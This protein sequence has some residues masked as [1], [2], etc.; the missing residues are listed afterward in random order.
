MQ[1]PRPL[2]FA[3]L[4][5][6][7]WARYQ[8][9]AWQ[10]VAG[11]QCVAIYNRTLE[12]AQRLA[13]EFNI[14]QATDDA[15]NLLS[16]QSLD[17]VDIVTD[18]D[19]HS[20]FVHLAAQHR[21]PAIC[22]KPLAPSLAVAEK[23][24]VACRTAGVPLLVHENFR[25]QRPMREVK[26]IL[27]E[28]TIGRPFRARIDMISGFPVFQNQP[29]LKGL[30]Q[31]ILTDLGTHILDVARFLFGEADRLYCETHRVHPDIRGEDVATVVT[32]HPAGQTTV[33]C[34]LAYAENHLA[35]ECFPQTLLFIEG[36]QGSLDLAPDYWIHITTAQ[37]TDSRQYPPTMYP[38]LDP[39]YAVVQSSI[40][41]CH[42]DLLRSLADPN[43]A[44]ETTAEDNLRTLQLVFTAYDS[45]AE[46]KAITL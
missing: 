10:E 20:H 4:G 13:H 15:E 36:T 30:A 6:G 40:V 23:M 42:R 19:S 26:R 34:N 27:D 41:D 24:A 5:A 37:G 29:F 7:F 18:V 12:K 45:A 11:A 2:R 9:A 8:L 33:V 28:G 1:S 22:Q 39:A 44:A 21:L 35:R 25:W 43:H 16:T 3:L 38:W 32:H 14:P 17:F 46:P 31:F